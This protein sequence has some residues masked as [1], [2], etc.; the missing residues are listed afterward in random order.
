MVDF[1]LLFLEDVCSTH[2]FRDHVK[3]NSTALSKVTR[4]KE[5]EPGGAVCEMVCM[6]RPGSGSS[7]FFPSGLH[8]S[9]IT[10]AKEAGKCSPLVCPGE[11]QSPV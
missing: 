8:Y 3:N 10:A 7:I 4:W 6:A 9:H 2:S 5:T 1:V 11:E